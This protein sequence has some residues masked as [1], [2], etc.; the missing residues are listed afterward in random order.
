M[1]NLLVIFNINKYKEKLTSMDPGSFYPWLT[2]DLVVS[3]DK[4]VVVV[5][6]TSQPSFQIGCARSADAN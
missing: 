4:V 1:E 2:I 6:L 5:V 3:R